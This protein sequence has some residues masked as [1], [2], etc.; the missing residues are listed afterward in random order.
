M[1]KLIRPAI[2]IGISLIL[3]LFSAALTQSFQ[4]PE[5]NS[6]VVAAFFLQTTPTPEVVDI[7]EVG[8]TDKIAVMGFVIVAIVVL[9]ILL[10]RKA[11]M[12]Q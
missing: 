10:R 8:S 4:P 2:V 7:S 11:W 9:P 5:G 12:N 3:A 1:K 6:R